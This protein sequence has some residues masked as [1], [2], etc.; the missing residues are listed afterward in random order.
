MLREKSK[1]DYY[2]KKSHGICV[3]CGQEKAVQSRVKCA[4][5]FAKGHKVGDKRKDTP[6]YKEYQKQYNYNRYYYRKERG[7]CVKCGKPMYKDSNRLSYEHY[8]KE[9]NDSAKRPMPKSEV[10]KENGLCLICGKPV[11]EL[12]GG[13][14][15]SRTL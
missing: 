13:Q 6:E 10:Y 9:K 8:I 12:G 14:I 11:C 15:L 3:K 5:C 4:D 2:F 7:L 1:A